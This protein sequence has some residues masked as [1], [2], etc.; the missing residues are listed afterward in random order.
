[1]SLRLKFILSFVTASLTVV[2][3]FA[4]ISYSSAQ[5]YSR[6][7]G[8][9][10]VRMNTIRVI[11]M[12]GSDLPILEQLEEMVPHHQEDGSYY[13]VVDSETGHIVS[14]RE[15]SLRGEITR[16][17]I[18]NSGVMDDKTQGIVSVKGEK[19]FWAV[20]H[21][22][23]T[24]YLLFNAFYQR[25]ES[26]SKFLN[27]IGLTL[28]ISVFIALWFSLWA[29]TILANLY[30]RLANQKTEIEYKAR[31]DP[32]TSLPNRQS[33]GD[34]I[35]ESILDNNDGSENL[36]LCLVEIRGL[37][38]INDSLGHE[39]GDVILR[40]I[41]ER[42]SAALRTSDRVGR[43]DGDKFA[44]I[45]THSK[46]TVVD[47]L[48]QRLLSAIDNVFHVGEHSLF[49]SAT[50][51]VAGYPGNA[52][53][54]QTLIQKTEIALHKA[55]D[56]GKDFV[57]FE[58][59]YDRGSVIKLELTNDLRSA[60]REGALELYYQPQIDLRTGEIAGFEA[61]ARWEHP[62]HGFISPDVFI[63]IA[64][65][66]GLIK[67]LTEWVLAAAIKQCAVWEKSCPSLTMSI[68]LS[69]RNLHD[70]TLGKQVAQHIR[71]W[72]ISPQQVCLEITETAMMADPEHAMYVLGELDQ[73]GVKISIDDFGTGYSS[74]SYLK[75]LPVDEIKIDRSFVMEMTSDEDDAAIIRATV[76]LAHDL[77]LSVVA[78]GVEDQAA[79]D[80]L[81]ELGCEYAQ[82]YHICKPAPA[83]QIDKL[84]ETSPS[85]DP[86]QL[87]NLVPI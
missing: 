28:G 46:T 4:V 33:I 72:Q 47:E 35:Q 56:S 84:L 25:E 27:Y 69:A 42:L 68:N 43:F 57:I 61:L 62:E 77:G 53:D 2:A 60:I 16:G 32:L 85:G 45:L 52:K 74:L 37:K 66:T 49:I 10:H 39:C 54:P 51:G 75:K 80:T 29:A 9:D 41:S 15:P 59:K 81:Q 86:G 13:I 79:Q 19:Y 12:L 63:D 58:S 55:K 24:H 30:Q 76:G 78:E 82:G 44:V 3:L 65:R 70:E 48:C 8:L 20:N 67:Q 34:I 64:E 17:L 21:I 11:N 83:R 50:L 26:A 7:A 73:L 31:H 87:K 23:D 14:K 38:D 40:Q 1:M 22:P 36:L 5:D 6:Q 71:H 18:L